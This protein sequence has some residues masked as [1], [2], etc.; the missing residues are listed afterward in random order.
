MDILYPKSSEKKENF[1]GTDIFP[2]F[3]HNRILALMGAIRQRRCPSGRAILI[4]SKM[5]VKDGFRATVISNCIKPRRCFC[6]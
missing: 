1:N 2:C 3:P 6:N 5:L 4:P